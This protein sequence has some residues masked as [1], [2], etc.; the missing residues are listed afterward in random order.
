MLVLGFETSTPKLS[1]ALYNEQSILVEIIVDGKGKQPLLQAVEE[2][3]LLAEKKKEELTG[4]AY[5]KG[6]GA[7]TGLRVGLATAKG[8]A[9]TLKLPIVG[10]GTLLALAQRYQ[11]THALVA[12]LLDA[13]KGEIYGALYAQQTEVLQACALG[14]QEMRAALTEA[15]AGRPILAVGD[16]AALLGDLPNGLLLPQLYPTASEIARLGAQ[17][18][19]QGEHD[20]LT[21]ATPTYLR[22]PEAVVKAQEKSA[23][24]QKS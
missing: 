17:L 1:V 19:A 12:P 6:P 11:N 15:A 22:L 2:A 23:A 24:A 8:I 3:F 10:V 9:Y 13:K 4:I 21:A 7:F 14:P 20:D 18:L 5:S 16:G